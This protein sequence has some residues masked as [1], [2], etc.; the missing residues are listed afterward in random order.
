MLIRHSDGVLFSE[1]LINCDGTDETIVSET[2]CLVPISSFITTPF[3]LE[4][5][6]SVWAK[7]RAT[8]LVGDSS[9]SAVGNGGILLTTPGPPLSLSDNVAVS[10]KTQIG[11]T[12]Y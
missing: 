8:N 4:F 6:S 11:L 2:K 1:E 12:W 7:V 3:N 9:Y 10:D 5:G